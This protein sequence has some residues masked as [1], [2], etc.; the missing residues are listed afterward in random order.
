M[1]QE[2]ARTS[3]GRRRKVSSKKRACTCHAEQTDCK[4]GVSK[5]RIKQSDQEQPKYLLKQSDQEQPTH[6][7]YD[8]KSYPSCPTLA[9]WRDH[10][11]FDIVASVGRC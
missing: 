11:P 3:S 6:I 2:E 8:M 4:S 9:A 5:R 7:L 1:L 10:Q